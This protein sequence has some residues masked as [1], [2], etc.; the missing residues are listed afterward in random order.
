MVL[1]QLFLQ[2]ESVFPWR[3]PDC[4]RHVRHY[5]RGELLVERPKTALIAKQY[6][7]QIVAEMTVYFAGEIGKNF[8][9]FSFSYFPRSERAILTG[10]MRQYG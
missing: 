5:F 7:R 10:N 9:I 3:S 6:W 2:G 8:A 4:V 1:F